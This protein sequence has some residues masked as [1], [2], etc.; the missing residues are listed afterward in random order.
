MI[1]TG[2]T[3]FRRR[4]RDRHVLVILYL[5]WALSTWYHWGS[6]SLDQSEAKVT[7]GWLLLCEA[8]PNPSPWP[9]S[10]LSK[11]SSHWAHSWSRWLMIH[12]LHA[13]GKAM[14]WVSVSPKIPILKPNSQSVGIMAFWRWLGHGTDPWKRKS[15][16]F[17]KDAWGSLRAFFLMC[18]ATQKVQSMRNRFS[19]DYDSAGVDFTGFRTMGDTFLL[20]ID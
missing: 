1:N 6:W 15:V 17:A 3:G 13:K 20:L 2:A 4:L 12:P 16:S 14:I 9:C 5:G 10:T 8:A 7:L 18:K 19:L 11:E